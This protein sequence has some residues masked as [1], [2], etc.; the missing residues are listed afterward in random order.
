MSDATNQVH[1]DQHSD[2]PATFACRH[3]R[4]G[5]GCGFHCSRDNPADP[6]PDAWCDRCQAEFEREGEWNDANEPEISLLCTGCYETARERNERLPAPLMPKQLAVSESD[7]A[8]LAHQACERCKT[9]Q[10]ATR[11]AWPKFSSAS[12]WHY[13]GEAGTIRFFDDER[14]S[15]LV[16]DVTIAGSFSTRSNTWMWAWANESY[17]DLER[18]KVAP[19]RIFGEVRGIDKFELPQMAGRRSRRL[20][21]HPDRSRPARIRCYL[22]SAD[23]SLAGLHAAR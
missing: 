13:D 6:W 14:E 22:S 3:L 15:S 5:V 7:F 19:L 1:C 9:R 21:S 10:Q 23:G 8:D 11:Q 18:K 16:A 17:P 4:L 20:G 12:Q 2:T